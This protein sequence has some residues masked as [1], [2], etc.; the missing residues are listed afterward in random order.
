MARQTLP[1]AA[2]LRE[3][4]SLKFGYTEDGR[5]REGF[6][7]RHGG[8]LFAYRNQCRHIPMTMDWVE[9]RFLSRDGCHI[10]CATHGALYDI[11]SGLCVAG[12]PEGKIL[13]RFEIETDGDEVV[14]ILP[15]G[16]P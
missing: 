5:E 16:G 13:G 4:E 9:N 3:G 14:V 2:A 15:E 11:A 1:G 7:V 12:P 8:R 6:I 10:Q